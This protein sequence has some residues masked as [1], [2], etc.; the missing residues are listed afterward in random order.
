MAQEGG[1][2]G[3]TGALSNPNAQCM[4]H[5]SVNKIYGNWNACYLCGFD[6][7]DGHSSMTCPRDWH[8]PTHIKAFTHGNAQSYI[9]ADY[10]CCTKGIHKT[11]LSKVAF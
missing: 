11:V 5:S 7:K 6:I 9:A 3:A 1:S 2:L 4:T 8:K 10:N